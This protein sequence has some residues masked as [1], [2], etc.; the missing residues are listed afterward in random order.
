MLATSVWIR[1]SRVGIQISAQDLQIAR[2]RIPVFIPIGLVNDIYMQPTINNVICI[3]YDEIKSNTKGIL[4]YVVHPADAHL[5]R[6]DFRIVKQSSYA[7]GVE[8]QLIVD[9]NSIENNRLFSPTS[10]KSNDIYR[11]GKTPRHQSPKRILYVRDNDI[12]IKKEIAPTS[13]LPALPQLAYTPYKGSYH[14]S[15]DDSAHRRHKSPRKTKPGHTS[16][17][18]G[19]DNGSKNRQKYR[20][21]SPQKQIKPQSPLKN[22]SHELTQEQIN[23]QQ[24]QQQEQFLIQQQQQIA[25]WQAA[26]QMPII[27]MG[28]YNR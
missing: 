15:R 14:S 20:S 16:S 13:A 10:Q 3:V 6:D 24:Q 12:G 8:N 26:Q 2:T 11:N 21:R 22:N 4:L 19:S 7:K 25:A 28:I 9:T 18:T 1:I 27:P 23:Q 5:L 17:K